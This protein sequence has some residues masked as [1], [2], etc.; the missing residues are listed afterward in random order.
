MTATVGAFEEERASTQDWIAVIAGALGALVVSLDSSIVNS[1]LP[2]IQGEIGASGTEGTWISTGYLVSEVVIIPLTAWLSRAFGMRNLLLGCTVMFTLFSM[3]C[4]VSHTLTAMIVGRMGQGLFGGA[5]VP[6]AQTIVRTRLPPRQMPIGMTL[7]GLIVLQGPLAGPLVGGWLTENASWQWCFF[8]NLPIAIG[9]VALLLLG[10][11]NRKTH[12]AE[13][14]HADWLGIIGMTLGL[15]CLT[16][17]LE[18]GQR[19]RWLESHLIVWLCLLS[20]TG[21]ILVGVAQ[22]VSR[23]PVLKLRLLLNRNYAAVIVIVVAIGMA[24]YGVIYLIPQF[25]SGIAGYNSSQSGRI[26]FLSG[27]PAFLM[28]PILPRIMRLNTRMLVIIGLFLFASSCFMDA[29]LT[30]QAGGEVFVWS[31]MLR[32]TGQIFASMPL[33]Q[34][35]VAAVGVAE[36][37][38]AAGFYNMA[39]NLGGSMGLALM[40][41]FIDRQTAGQAQA[42]AGAVSANSLTGQSYLAA[43]TA[44]MTARNGGNAL[45]AHAQ[46]FSSLAGLIQQ[47]ATVITYCNCFTVLGFTILALIPLTFLLRT[48]GRIDFASS[49]GH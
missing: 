9:L 3:V 7:F 44:A 46:A 19:E 31:Q 49:S 24:L 13:L 47:Q 32:G 5:L 14:F 45:L 27:V 42:L 34:A 37:A 33:N 8:L 22:L 38:D 1:A 6:T 36:A 11:P 18:E 35:S 23:R 29:H 48:P 12:L 43:Q 25:L 2:Q 16:I 10:L 41:V 30:A 39:R 40:G 21:F 20:L 17:V 4:G 28:M 26:L 15:S